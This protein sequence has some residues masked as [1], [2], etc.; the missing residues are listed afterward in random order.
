VTAVI[1]TWPTGKVERVSVPAVN[2]LLVVR[3]GS[4]VVKTEALRPA[5]PRA[6]R[7][8]GTPKR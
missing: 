7:T 8:P 3:E 5:S 2:R 1:V 4:G 6:S